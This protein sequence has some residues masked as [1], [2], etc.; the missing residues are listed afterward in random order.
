MLTGISSLSQT[1]SS[2]VTSSRSDT[3]KEYIYLVRTAEKIEEPFQW[4]AS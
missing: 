1:E 4:S 2:I 3:Q